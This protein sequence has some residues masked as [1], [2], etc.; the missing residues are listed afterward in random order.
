M[1]LD[2]LRTGTLLITQG[3][4]LFV[5]TLFPF[6][7]KESSREI[8]AQQHEIPRTPQVLEIESIP[9]TEETI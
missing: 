1:S 2:N 3:L 7:F 9:L 5:N 4:T 8:T 6:I